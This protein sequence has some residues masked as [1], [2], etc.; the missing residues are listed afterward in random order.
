MSS[1]THLDDYR[2]RRARMRRP[3]N[4][5]DIAQVAQRMARHRLAMERMLQETGRGWRHTC[6][7]TGDTVMVPNGEV[8]LLCGED[9]PSSPDGAA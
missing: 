9:D 7:L 3:E 8:C 6:T 2:I 5:V 4:V 1:I